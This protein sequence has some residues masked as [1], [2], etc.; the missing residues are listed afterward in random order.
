[1]YLKLLSTSFQEGRLGGFVSTMTPKSHCCFILE[2]EHIRWASRG[3]NSHSCLHGFDP[4]FSS[5]LGTSLQLPY[6]QAFSLLFSLSP[7]HLAQ[8]DAYTQVSSTFEIKSHSLHIVLYMNLI[9]GFFSHLNCLLFLLI[10]LFVKSY[11]F[12]WAILRLF[13]KQLNIGT[14][15]YAYILIGIMSNLSSCI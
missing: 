4:V 12:L 11:V 13:W 5:L 8:E 14:C 6:L 2:Y 10:L 3:T 1:M 9:V 7:F 15:K